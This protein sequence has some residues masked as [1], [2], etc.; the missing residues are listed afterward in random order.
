M[1][2]LACRFD[3]RLVKISKL[4]IITATFVSNDTHKHSGIVSRSTSQ[5]RHT[6]SLRS[7]ESIAV[8]HFKRYA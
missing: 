7:V 5:S 3:G 8:N 1:L 4:S 2:D 6:I